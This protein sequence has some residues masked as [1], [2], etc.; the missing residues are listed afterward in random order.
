MQIPKYNAETIAA[1]EEVSAMKQNP[2][3]YRG[4]H[5]IEDLFEELESDDEV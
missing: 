4:F 2:E 5:N 1:I 3:R